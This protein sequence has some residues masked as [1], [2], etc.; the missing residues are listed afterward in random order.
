[1]R[2]KDQCGCLVKEK[3]MCVLDEALHQTCFRTTN[4][5][6][7]ID[8]QF[9]HSQRKEWI[10]N[11]YI[12]LTNLE[13]IVPDSPEHDDGSVCQRHLLNCIVEQYHRT[14]AEETSKH[15]INTLISGTEE[16][17]PGGAEKDEVDGWRNK[18]Q[19]GRDSIQK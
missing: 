2:D 19:K 15:Q 7:E 1:M 3:E 6:Q 5:L 17:G 18:R 13:Q 4:R 14:G 16:T 9:Y 10:H 8:G 11:L 12:I